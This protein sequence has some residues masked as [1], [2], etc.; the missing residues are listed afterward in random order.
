M[1]NSPVAGDLVGVMGFGFRE[2]A[3]FTVVVGSKSQSDSVISDLIDSWRLISAGLIVVL[4]LV[5][6][7]S[8]V[9]PRVKSVSLLEFQIRNHKGSTVKLQVLI[10]DF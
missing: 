7:A 8:V 10:T 4:L 6:S 3:G 9:S 1:K 5:V 2:A